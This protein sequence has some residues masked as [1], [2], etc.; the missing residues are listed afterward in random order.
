MSATRLDNP[1][2]N[3]CFGCG[4]RHARGLRLA[5]ER[6]PAADG[7]GDEIVTTYAPRPDEI[8]WPGLLH[9]GL[10]F[11]VLYEASYWCA[12]ELGGRVMNSVGDVV[13]TPKRLP[14]T[15]APFRVRARLSERSEDGAKTFA[16]SESL[17]GK[18]YGTVAGSWRRASRAR[19]EK[20]GL[21]LPDYLLEDMDP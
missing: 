16:Q 14:P 15:G 2:E 17:E 21:A 13:Y 10:H 20:A 8:G 3:P 19:I 18:P 12:L 7:S 11:T 5:F 9:T 1:S 4:P 6:L